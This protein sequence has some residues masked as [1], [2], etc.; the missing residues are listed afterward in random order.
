MI[1]RI[2]T[3]ALLGLLA[4][5]TLSDSAQAFGG[6]RPRGTYTYNGT[7]GY[8]SYPAAT[9]AAPCATGNCPRQNTVY[10]SGYSQPAYYYAP[11]PAYTV[12]PAPVYAPTPQR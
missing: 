6:G 9:T 12:S 4:L 11:R 8:W 2:L 1:R 5:A 3:A 10:S 7:T